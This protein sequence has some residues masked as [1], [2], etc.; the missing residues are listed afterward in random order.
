MSTTSTSDL[1]V[2]TY[3][4]LNYRFPAVARHN[5]VVLAFA[6]DAKRSIYYSVLDFGPGGSMSMLDADHWSPNPRPLT[7][8]GE[9]ASV[10]FGVADQ[11]AV[12]TVRKGS[13][14]AVPP[15]Q[16]VRPD[17]TDPFLSTT[18]RFSAAVPFQVV[19]DGRY[20]YVFRQASTDP[21][22]AAV[23]AAQLVLLD[24]K[25][26][27]DALAQARD[28]IADHQNMAYVSDAAGAPVLD[29]HGRQIPVVAG[30]LLVDRF[31]LVGTTLVPKLEVRYQ[32]S[33]SRTRPAGTTDSLGA[34]DLNRQPF[35]EP[36]QNLRFVPS[37]IQGRFAATLVPTQVAEVFRWQLFTHDA[38]GDVIWSYSVERTADGLFDTLGTQPLTCTDHPDVYAVTAGSCPR[39]SVA[40]PTVV[41]GKTLVAKLADGGASGTAL[42]FP[43][44]GSG[45]VT[46]NG[47]NATGTE[48]TVERW[49]APDPAATGERA[50]VTCAGDPKAAGPSI[51]LHD[52][53]TLR[54]GFGDGQAF[55]DV[56]TPPVLAPG[57]WN[58]LAVTYAAGLLQV[59]VNGQVQ[60]ASNA[61][62]TAVPSPT[63]IAAFGAPSGG[64]AGR[65]DDVRVWSV[66]LAAQDIQA[67]RC[68]TLTGLEAGL[69]G[70]WRFDE[71]IG[72]A[73][74]DAASDAKALLDGPTWVTS[75]APIAVAPGLSRSAL[76]LTGRSVTGGLTAALYYQQDNAV[77]GY[78]G[79]QPAPLKQAARVMLAAVTTA[80]A[81]SIT[82]AACL[83]GAGWA[84][85]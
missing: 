4:D 8:A 24:P 41:C 63:P 47:A 71:G 10:G 61:F 16:I 19:S 6:M 59:Y 75:D 18:A 53:Q 65:L 20:V 58:H 54:I 27:P 70:Y 25:A 48:F 38:A 56:T 57:E 14:T 77:S 81:A 49:L 68:T 52:P 55:H 31:V 2:K 13:T 28:T 21:T 15:G 11:S 73:T 30:T 50:L 62:G 33:R 74:W 76:R 3:A 17:E 80:T 66:A 60:F 64:F 44:D 85:G 40:D 26:T 7:F 39:P 22:A 9:I 36:T 78:P 34:A 42:S 79:A 5:G 43:T 84:P 1:F 51:W 12:P 69:V 45:V 23:N 83:S 29:A 72:T 46:I 37:I 32:R 82:R 67:G 35:I